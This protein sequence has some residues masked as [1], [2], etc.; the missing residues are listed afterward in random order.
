MWVATGTP[1]LNGWDNCDVK[2]WSIHGSSTGFGTVSGAS[3]DPTTGNAYVSNQTCVGSSCNFV[4]DVFQPGQN[5]NTAPYQT[6]GSSVFYCYE[7]CFGFPFLDSAGKIWVGD[8]TCGDG[9]FVPDIYVFNAG[10]HG[11]NVTPSQDI[12]SKCAH[13]IAWVSFA[14]D[15][16][17]HIYAEA[18]NYD[19]TTK[20]QQFH[21]DDNGNVTPITCL[22]G[23]NIDSALVNTAMSDGIAIGH[24]GKLY[25]ASEYAGRNLYGYPQGNGFVYIWNAGDTGNTAPEHWIGGSNTGFVHPTGV[26]ISGNADGYAIYVAD[27][28]AGKIDKFAAGSTGN[29]TPSA[30]YSVP[31]MLW[32]ASPALCSAQVL[33]NVL[34]CYSTPSAKKHRK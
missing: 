15:A 33:N 18:L 13:P 24:N 4:L 8:Y 25:A 10:A 32:Q 29:A 11:S 28:A 9:C 31:N 27:P 7:S 23:S 5:G 12:T 1:S 22:N 14:Q 26:A 19:T 2:D 6:L 20:I 21:H 17:G 34:E 16:S 3:I 30:T